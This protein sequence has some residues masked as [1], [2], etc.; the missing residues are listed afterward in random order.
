[1]GHL[2]AGGLGVLHA[3]A[4]V[5]DGD[6]VRGRGAVAVV[7]AAHV[8]LILRHQR[9]AREPTAGQCLWFE[10]QVI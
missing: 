10:C 6:E 8:R 7:P 1:M 5:G 3:G 9:V 2:V 4:V